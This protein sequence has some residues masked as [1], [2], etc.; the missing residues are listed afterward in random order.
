MQFGRVKLKSVATGVDG[1]KLMALFLDVGYQ[2]R[3]APESI[4]FSSL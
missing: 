1:D 4:E 3:V 2:Q